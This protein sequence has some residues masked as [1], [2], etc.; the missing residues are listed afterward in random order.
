MKCHFVVE[1]VKLSA[2][3]TL[4]ILVLMVN[5]FHIIAMFPYYQLLLDIF[6]DFLARGGIRVGFCIY[7]DKGVGRL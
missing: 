7:V 4:I 6:L 1:V 3:I 2:I 5:G